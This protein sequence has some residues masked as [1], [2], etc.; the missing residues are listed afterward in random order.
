MVIISKVGHQ[1][2]IIDRVC[3]Q[4]D[5]MNKAGNQYHFIDRVCHPDVMNKA[6]NQYHSYYRLSIKTIIITG[7][8]DHQD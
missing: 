1:D 3:H 2:H 4:D 8:V 5:V 6:G 7:K